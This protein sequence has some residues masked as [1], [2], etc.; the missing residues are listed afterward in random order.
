ML[1]R[2]VE[3]NK[4]NQSVTFKSL[5]RTLEDAGHRDFDFVCT[6]HIDV[7]QETSVVLQFC[8]DSARHFLYSGTPREEY[9]VCYEESEDE[10]QRSSS[11]PFIET[12]A[13]SD[14]PDVE[15]TLES[16]RPEWLDWKYHDEA[17]PEYRSFWWDSNLNPPIVSNTVPSPQDRRVLALQTR[18]FGHSGY[19]PFGMAVPV[20][21]TSPKLHA[22][23]SHFTWLAR[24]RAVNTNLCTSVS[25]ACDSACRPDACY[26]HPIVSALSS[27]NVATWKT[28]VAVQDVNNDEDALHMVC[29]RERDLDGGEGPVARICPGKISVC[30]YGN[31]ASVFITVTDTEHRGAAFTMEALKIVVVTDM[32]TCCWTGAAALCPFHVLVDDV[33]PDPKEEHHC[34]VITAEDVLGV[35]HSAVPWDAPV[36]TILA[37]NMPMP[38]SAVFHITIGDAGKYLRAHCSLAAIEPMIVAGRSS[39]EAKSGWHG[40]HGLQM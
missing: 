40:I 9:R 19:V 32:M 28:A 30:Y 4:T 25:A 26:I 2:N 38:P 15:E 33:P 39:E 8:S 22:L 3:T 29:Y 31:V 37:H 18:M 36:E 14:E 10:E 24:T 23:P 11:G 35:S 17:S 27:E 16:H 7:E 13:G 1:W 34:F 5:L 6:N 12:S 20:E 21:F